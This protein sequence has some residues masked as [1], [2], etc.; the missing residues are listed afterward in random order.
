VECGTCDAG[1]RRL[2][3]DG[4]PVPKYVGMT[5][6]CVLWFVFYCILLIAF[7]GQSND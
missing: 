4:T 1:V 5:M 2:P 3:A 6:N 7:V